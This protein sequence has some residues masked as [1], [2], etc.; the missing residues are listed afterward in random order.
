M[1]S[2]PSIQLLPGLFA[3]GEQ[4]RSS[5][6][7]ILD[8][9]IVGFEVGARLGKATYPSLI[10]EGWFPVGVLGTVM[11]TAACAR[12]LSLKPD[13]VRAALGVA[14]NTASGLRCN[15][16]FMAKPLMAGQ[17]GS[18]GVLAATLASAGLTANP[19]ALEAEFGFIANFS[20]R[21]GEHLAE[22]VECLERSVEDLGRHFEILSSGITHKLH[23]CCAG[24]HVPID[25]ALEIASTPGFDLA[26]IRS[27]D[28]RVHYGV[29]YL[30][31][32]QRPATEAEARFSL[33]YAVARALMDG[34]MRP[35]QFTADKVSELD[36]QSLMERIKP[37]FY[38]ESDGAPSSA[39]GPF[40]VEL[41]VEMNNGRVLTA[42]GEHARGTPDNPLSWDE[43]AAKFRA[44]TARIL[45]TAE[46]D[47]VI[48]HVADFE[49]A[50]DVT[51]LV[52]HL[53]PR[54][55]YHHGME[56]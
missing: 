7:Q 51:E 46:A 32:H 41:R 37:S 1:M 6:V 50:S 42:R 25:C 16:G 38:G 54:A 27:V 45:P 47:H 3:L 17:V 12:L 43:L 15:S 49:D 5:G 44:N 34:T 2:H 4:R 20:G 10:T 19:N 18:N 48:E 29:Q 21:H 8:A 24:G 14:A 22:A 9:Y 55:R 11:Q 30:L 39:D 53:S 35:E 13:A 31:I 52:A 28:V 26:E 56:V 23:S 40:P 36:V 33:E